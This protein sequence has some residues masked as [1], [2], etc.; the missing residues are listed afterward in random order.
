MLDMAMIGWVGA[1]KKS[2]VVKHAGQSQEGLVA[3]LEV[4]KHCYSSR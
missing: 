2:V 1:V 4:R 3:S